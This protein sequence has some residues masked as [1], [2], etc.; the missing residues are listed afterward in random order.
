MR[1]R[2]IEC[3]LNMK[4]PDP[5]LQCSPASHNSTTETKRSVRLMAGILYSRRQQ[6]GSG[7]WNHPGRYRE[8]DK[9]TSGLEAQRPAVAEPG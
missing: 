9:V 6:C 8:D 3:P 2:A 4:P 1:Q 7:Y 5:G